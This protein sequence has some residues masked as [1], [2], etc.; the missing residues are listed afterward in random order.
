[1]AAMPEAPTQWKDQQSQ[2]T[3]NLDGF[4]PRVTALLGNLARQGVDNCN[5]P[6]DNNYCKQEQGN[7]FEVHYVISYKWQCLQTI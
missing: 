4:D 2:V 7:Y 3:G 6:H 1:M 5:F